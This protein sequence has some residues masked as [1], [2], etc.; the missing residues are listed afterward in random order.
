MADLH[1]PKV[2]SGAEDIG[3]VGDDKVGERVR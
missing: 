3:Q 2:L 1:P